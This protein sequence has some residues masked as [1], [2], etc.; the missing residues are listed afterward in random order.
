MKW[1]H[2]AEELRKRLPQSTKTG[3]QCRER[4]RNYLDPNITKKEWTKSDK[5]LFL[6]LHRQSGNRW[7]QIAK[8]YNGR[9]DISLKNLFYSF[10]RR[11]LRVLKDGIVPQSIL[12]KPRKL[13]ENYYVVDVIQTKY[14]PV[15]ENQSLQLKEE[16][17]EKI[18]LNLISEKHISEKAIIDY[19]K[20]LISAYKESN[21]KP[22]A[23][24]E[25]LINTEGLNLGEARLDRLKEY[26]RDQDFGE[27]SKFIVIKL[28]QPRDKPA[29]ICPVLSSHEEPAKD[30]NPNALL[31]GFH[32]PAVLTTTGAAT[33]PLP[34]LASASPI[35]FAS[36]SMQVPTNSTTK[37]ALIRFEPPKL[38]PL[39]FK[40]RS[41]S[42]SPQC[43]SK[44]RIPMAFPQQRSQMLSQPTSFQQ[45]QIHSPLMPYGSPINSP[46]LMSPQIRTCMSSSPFSLFNPGQRPMYM[47]P[48]MYPMDVMQGTPM[49]SPSPSNTSALNPVYSPHSLQPGF[50]G[51]YS[52]PEQAFEPLY[53]MKR[54]APE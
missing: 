50:P 12:S 19:K 4:Y 20:E 42:P 41:P 9:S 15:L 8:Y 29:P 18:L 47:W 26:V 16:K 21:D 46:H 44:P 54:E 23:P 34:S 45:V 40:A 36:C 11:A 27:L 38:P 48:P 5:L 22:G 3:K 13:L 28:Q 49:M 53:K 14:L 39:E 43:M 51:S 37:P 2:V 52:R 10:V 32:S 25:L 7:G 1:G 35:P 6:L 30:Y 17:N 24:A 33:P 31:Q